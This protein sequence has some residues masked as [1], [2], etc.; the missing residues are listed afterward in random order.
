[1]SENLQQVPVCEQPD[2][3]PLFGLPGSSKSA[4][5]TIRLEPT[6]SATTVQDKDVMEVPSTTTMCDNEATSPSNNCTFLKAVSEEYRGFMRAAMVLSTSVFEQQLRE[7]IAHSRKDGNV[8]DLENKV[9]DE[10]RTI[11]TLDGGAP[12]HWDRS[13][14]EFAQAMIGV[15]SAEE[16]Q[17]SLLAAAQRYRLIMEWNMKAAADLDQDILRLIRDV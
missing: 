8:D 11:I 7:Y 4:P 14:F 15:S 5:G 1:M 6:S 12:Y 16:K 3:H 13:G 9:L 2:Q 17:G 10:L